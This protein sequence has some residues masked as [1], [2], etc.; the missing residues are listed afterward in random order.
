M[1]TN[2]EAVVVERQTAHKPEPESNLRRET[3]KLALPTIGEMLMQTLLGFADMAMVGGLGAAAI[4]AVGLSDTPM[5]TAM[6]LFAAISVGTTALVARAIGAKEPAEAA[7]VAKQSLLVSIAMAF[8][9]TTLGLVLARPIIVLMGAEADVVPLSTAYFQI[10]CMGLPLMIISMIMA[11]VLR[12]SGDT[13][14]PMYINGIANILNIIGNFFLIFPTRVWEF[15]L[16]GVSHALTIPGAGLG[17]P[18]AAISTT[19]SRCFAGIVILMLIFR[20]GVRVKINWREPFRIDL[21]VIRRIFKIG[22]PAAAEQMVMR[23]GQLFYGRIVASLGTMLY[24]AHRITLTAESVSFNVGF[25]FALAA[26]T[27]VGQNLGAEKPEMAE[28][29]GF[30]AVK[31]GAIFMSVVGIFFLFWPDLFLRIF[32][33]DPEILKNARV[34]L[35]IVAVSQ[36]FLAAVMGFA[37]GLR[38]AG[39]TKSVLYVTLLGMWGLRLTLSWI[40]CVILDWGLAGAWIAMTIDLILRGSMLLVRFKK[41]R[42]KAI[43][44]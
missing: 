25:G 24:A 40:L 14:T 20:G 29:S 26:T 34:C 3:L 2:E 17:V 33:R 12:G 39:D 6:A 11:G 7:K 37:G 30:M 1:S 44:V 8:I 22:I 23:F 43:R 41:G 28:K 27:L 15:S 19:L 10:V 38:G 35:Q 36:P 16:G 42:W 32:T 5:M 4:A 21:P 18:G 13:K 9:F 31:M